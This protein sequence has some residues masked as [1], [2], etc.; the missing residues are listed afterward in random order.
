MSVHTG[1]PSSALDLC[2]CKITFF[3]WP[4]GN[5]QLDRKSNLQNYGHRISPREASNHGLN[6][7][8]QYS[9]E[10][11]VMSS[12][13][14]LKASTVQ[15]LLRVMEGSVKQFKTWTVSKIFLNLRFLRTTNWG[16]AMMCQLLRKSSHIYPGN[17]R[18]V[19][20]H[21]FIKHDLMHLF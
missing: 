2:H 8:S 5:N 13:I 18:L 15:D 11:L 4:D 6:S 21:R 1:C 16:S 19:S 20:P 12:S 3:M 10:F 14:R 9:I 17:S 7:I